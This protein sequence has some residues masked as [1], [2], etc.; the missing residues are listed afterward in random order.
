MPAGIYILQARRRHTRKNGAQII[1]K[2]Q[3]ITFIA[4]LA[5]LS[6]Q[7]ADRLPAHLGAEG[8]VLSWHDNSTATASTADAWNVEVNGTGCGNHELQ[9]Y[10]DAPE[11]VS[12]AD[13]C[14]LL[15]AIRRPYGDSHQFTSGRVNT[16]GK[17][18]LYLRHS[19]GA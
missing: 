12:V 15:T 3:L 16:H 13:G 6:T 4:A 5:A 11:A 14:L 8:Y 19:R 17:V 18:T 2:I 1:M 9:H 10:I 7:A